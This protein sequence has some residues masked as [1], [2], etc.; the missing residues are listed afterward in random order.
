MLETIDKRLP[1][2]LSREEF[3]SDK[4]KNIYTEIVDELASEKE[5]YALNDDLDEIYE[6]IEKQRKRLE[7]EY[8]LHYPDKIRDSEK[9]TEIINSCCLGK[10][11]K[12]QYSI[13]ALNLERFS[14]GY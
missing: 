7:Q 1:E 6:Y 13:N 9:I 2:V 3:E 5:A 12:V 14:F 10:I 8:A 4:I 11:R